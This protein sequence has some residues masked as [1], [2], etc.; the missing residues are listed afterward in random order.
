MKLYFTPL[1]CSMA[2]RITAYEA[3][4]PVTFVEVDPKIGQLP[5]GGDYH[6][7]NPLGQVPALM[8]DAGETMSEN[9]AVLQYLADQAPASG[10]VPRAGDIAR[11]H[12]QQWLSFIGTELHKQLF[13]PLLAQQSNDGAKDFALLRGARPLAR[14]NAHLVENDYLLDRFTVADAYLV[15]VLNWAQYCGLDLTGYTAI[16]AYLKRLKERPSIARAMAE[17]TD[18][19]LRKKAS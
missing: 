19:Y 2:S 5:D 9:A 18:L 17:E 15:A 1:A 4:L 16:S 7:I 13:I 11:Y 10:L 14:L 12:L 6:A 3:A 8:T